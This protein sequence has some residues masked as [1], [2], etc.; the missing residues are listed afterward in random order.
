MF[1][2]VCGRA[3]LCFPR[4]YSERRIKCA[5]LRVRVRELGTGLSR[6]RRSFGGYGEMYGLSGVNFG[7]GIC[8]T[9]IIPRVGYIYEEYFV[10]IISRQFLNLS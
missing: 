1:L 8:L 6:D 5:R 9:I 7:I 4:L 2:F 10:Q 3:Y